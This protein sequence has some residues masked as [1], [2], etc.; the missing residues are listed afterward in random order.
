MCHQ[1][2]PKPNPKKKSLPHS[3]LACNQHGAKI[4]VPTNQSVRYQMVTICKF[5][6][7]FH[8]FFVALFFSMRHL[9]QEETDFYATE[10][11][12]A[13]GRG[14]EG[15]QGLSKK[16]TCVAVQWNWPTLAPQKQVS[17]LKSAQFSPI[18]MP[19]HSGNQFSL[20]STGLGRGSWTLTVVAGLLRQER[21]W[22]PRV[23]DRGQHC[24]QSKKMTSHLCIAKVFINFVLGTPSWPFI[25]ALV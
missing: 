3:F 9:T 20:H 1:Y 5:C 7:N 13:R 2:T 23:G 11:L 4:F 19:M 17:N 25:I 16:S 6:E 12:H 8:S 18:L 22:K 24:G 10:T 15:R 14:R 21:N